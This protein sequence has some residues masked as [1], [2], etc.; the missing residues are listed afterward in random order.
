MNKTRVVLRPDPSGRRARL[1]LGCARSTA[2]GV[3]RPRLLSLGSASARVALIPEGALLLRGDEI[4]VDLVVGEGVRLEI[5]EP[6]GTVAYDMR[7]GSARWDVQ[8]AVETGGSLAWQAQPFVLAEGADVRRR[9]SARL[10]DD[11]ALLHRETLVLGRSGE[12]AGRL[13]LRTDV[14]RGDVPVLVEELTLGPGEPTVGVLGPHRVVDTLLSLGSSDPVAVPVLPGMAT[15]RLA[16]GGT[17]WRTLADA[18]HGAGL[19]EV[20]QILAA[21]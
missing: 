10:A 6:S 7:G 11:A 13:Q 18:S 5:I 12:G 15:Y 4:A 8:V 3:L 19:G 20:W 9:M 2:G 21:A 16:G 17:M 14:T 1:D